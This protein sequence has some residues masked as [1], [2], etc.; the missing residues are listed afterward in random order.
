MKE[1][2]H[3]GQ[4]Q[5]VPADINRALATTLTIARNEY[6]YVAE[7]ECDYGE[8]PL[9]PCHIGELNQVFLNIIV[10]AAHAIEAVT[11][12][13]ERKGLI[14]IE[15]RAE[16][17]RVRISISDTGTGIRGEIR[18][19][20]FDPFFT[21]KEVGKGTGQ[22]LSI[23][24]SVVVDKHRGS[25]TFDSELGRGSTFHIRLENASDRSTAHASDPVR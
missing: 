18:E 19:Q 17:D 7:V 13:S 10:N 6:K 8:L 24:R 14:R 21:T 4:K 22:G 23:A 20:I 12:G 1:F 11:R 2:A 15:T 5:K 25:L 16:G 9:V 3:P